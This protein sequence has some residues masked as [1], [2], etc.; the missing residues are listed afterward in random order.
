MS[1]EYEVASTPENSL[2]FKVQ[3]SDRGPSKQADLLE[4]FPNSIDH[5]WTENLRQNW[6]VLE[7]WCALPVVRDLSAQSLDAKLEN[8]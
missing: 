4:S 6:S 8:K 1:C 2:T 3:T 5:A 7:S